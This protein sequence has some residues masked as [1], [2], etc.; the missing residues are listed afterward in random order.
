MKVLLGIA[1]ALM[2]GACGTVTRGTTADVTFKS[3]PPGAKVQLSTG[4]VC[5][6]TPCT[7]QISRKQE[8]IAS[9]TMDGYEPQSI[10]VKTDVSGGGAA[11]FAGNVLVG[12]VIGMGVDVAT[13][14]AL[15]HQPNPVFATL[16]PVPKPQP[17]PPPISRRKRAPLRS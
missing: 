14:A 4:M 1:I 9:F 10:D 8:F 16:V 3:E 11:G 17:A 5:A 13:G 2:L 15:D 6:A 12:G 7:F